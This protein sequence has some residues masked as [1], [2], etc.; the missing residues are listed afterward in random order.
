MGLDASQTGAQLSFISLY[1]LYVQLSMWSL[2]TNAMTNPAGKD[3]PAHVQNPMRLM[4]LAATRR[5]SRAP[6]GATTTTPTLAP[7]ASIAPQGD[8]ATTLAQRNAP[9][10][11]PSTRTRKRA[12][13]RALTAPQGSFLK[14]RPEA[15]KNVDVPLTIT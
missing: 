14:P 12:L 11:A 4:P 9:E 1:N 8:S 6:K 3:K 7:R 2:L 5:A 10:S 15:S 13:L